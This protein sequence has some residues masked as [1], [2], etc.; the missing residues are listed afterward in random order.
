M[1]N[2]QNVASLFPFPPIRCRRIIRDTERALGDFRLDGESAYQL[3]ASNIGLLAGGSSET[4]HLVTKLRELSLCDLPG[5][6]VIAFSTNSLADT[7]FETLTE[8]DSP[9]SRED[10]W[11][12]G[13][14]TF[15]TPEKLRTIGK[16]Q[17]GGRPVLAIGLVDPPCILYKARGD[18]R[19]GF[20]FNDRPQHIAKFR[21][22]HEI[23]DWRP[24]FFLFTEQPAKSLNTNQML[25]PFSLEAW[26][27]LDGREIRMGTPPTIAPSVPAE[28]PMNDDNVHPNAVPSI[29]LPCTLTE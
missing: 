22:A 23:G 7:Y 16:P 20:A 13:S 19:R 28:S 14:V 6:I 9:S 27:F 15:S 25:G 1:L 29:T 4:R 11:T 26:W 17:L 21:A 3:G 24:P 8:D 18:A 12:F 2:S 10:S 5:Q